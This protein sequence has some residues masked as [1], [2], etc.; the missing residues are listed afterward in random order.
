MSSFQTHE[1]YLLEMFN[2]HAGAGQAFCDLL[3]IDGGNDI[4]MANL[5]GQDTKVKHVSWLLQEGKVGQIHRAEGNHYEEGHQLHSVYAINQKKNMYDEFTSKVDDLTQIFMIAKNAKPDIKARNQWQLEE[6]RRVLEGESPRRLPSEL[7][8]LILAWDG[9]Y[10]RQVFEVLYD[11]YNTP[12]LEEW[13][14]Y[15][16]DQLIN[17][18]LYEPLFVKC[19][20]S[21]YELEAG[22]LRVTEKQLEEIITE[23]IESYELDFAIE[24]D[25]REDHEG[26]LQ[27]CNS[28][29]DYLTNFAPE[30]GAG[31]QENVRLQFDPEE[32]R[33]HPAFRDVNLQANHNGITGLYPPQANTVMGVSKTLVND[34]FC[35]IIGEMG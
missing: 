29:D 22:L 16:V 9:D 32:E 25:G 28:I 34:D 8:E 21:D 3:V 17:R 14:E 20:G 23:G 12:M 6:E 13:A 7:S 5:I 4:Y 1:I 31:I 27:N 35:F 2:R 10:R 19:Y 26:V 15:L 33:H 30:L 24:E 18:K 11:R